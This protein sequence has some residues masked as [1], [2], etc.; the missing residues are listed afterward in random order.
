MQDIIQNINSIEK[1]GIIFAAVDSSYNT[2]T[3]A[4]G[5]LFFPD[6][7]SLRKY[8]LGKKGIIWLDELPEKNCKDC[9]GT[10]KSGH[11]LVGPPI[12]TEKIEDLIKSLIDSEPEK[13]PGEL[14]KLFGLAD[15]FIKP[16]DVLINTAAI[17]ELTPDNIDIVSTKYARIIKKDLTFKRIVWCNCFLKNL[18]K[19]IETVSRDI[20]FSVN[21]N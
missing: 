4:G 13:L 8:R 18:E 12:P 11:I 14:V 9:Y 7:T 10:G 17:K 20:K 2:P 19:A 21:I 1:E 5:I 6:E 3:T 15:N 16:F